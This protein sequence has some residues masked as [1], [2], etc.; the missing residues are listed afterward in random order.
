MVRFGSGAEDVICG[1]LTDE[2]E[3]KTFGSVAV[4]WFVVWVALVE[5]SDAV[6]WEAFEAFIFESPVC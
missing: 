1:R 6:S 5:V 3:E 2:V 4:A